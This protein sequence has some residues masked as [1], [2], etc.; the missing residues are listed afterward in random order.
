MPISD[1]ISDQDHGVD[2]I[3]DLASSPEPNTAS[4]DQT[5]SLTGETPEAMSVGILGKLQL[6][7]AFSQDMGKADK[8][9]LSEML[10]RILSLAISDGRTS[11]YDQI[12]E[13]SGGAGILNKRQNP[14]VWTRRHYSN[15]QTEK[16]KGH[17]PWFG[18]D[19]RR[20]P[21]DDTTLDI[22]PEARASAH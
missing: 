18:K 16:N 22:K 13:K 3:S 9:L 20:K 19:R 21:N 4:S 1:S 6:S 5:S 2:H 8:E 10:D 15:N 11:V 12:W 17:K 7:P 14:L